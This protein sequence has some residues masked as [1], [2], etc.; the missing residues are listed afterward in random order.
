MTTNHD[1]GQVK[2]LADKPWALQIWQC[3]GLWYNYLPYR[4]QWRI[5][6]KTDLQ[7]Q[8]CYYKSC[9]KFTGNDASRGILQ[10]TRQ[11]EKNLRQQWWTPQPVFDMHATTS[12]FIRRRSTRLERGPTKRS[13]FQFYDLQLPWDFRL[14]YVVEKLP[15]GTSSYTHGTQGLSIAI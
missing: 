7:Q 11:R 4:L 6:K 10:K 15:E 1:V 13:K 12:V 3:I 14:F 5:P 9:I 2:N 8:H